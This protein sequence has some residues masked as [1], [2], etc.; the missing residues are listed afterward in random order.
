[1]LSIQKVGDFAL[2]ILIIYWKGVSG[3][4]CWWIGS[5]GLIKCSIPK[6]KH[7]KLTSPLQVKC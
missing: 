7:R 3:L 4:E 5:L 2:T 1:M 6:L